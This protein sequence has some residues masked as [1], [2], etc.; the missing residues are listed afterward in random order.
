MSRAVWHQK[1]IR[2]CVMVLLAVVLLAVASASP[3]AQQPTTGLNIAPVYEGWEQNADGSFDLIFGYFNRNWNEWIDTPAGAANS[4]EPGGPDQGQPTHFLPRRNQFV[5]R[6]RVPRDFGSRELVWTLTTNGKTEK[7]Y[8]T[9]KPDYVVN[10]T[11]MAANFGAG[12]QTGT[13][14]DL[15]GNVAPV[16]K[17]EGERTR[18]VRV[19]EPVALV[20]V[21][22][23]DG[24]PRVRQ[25]QNF[26][27]RTV[28]NSATGLR[29]VWFKYRGAGDV[30]FDPPQFS[31]WED[32]RNGANSPWA[33]GWRT[34]PIPTDNTWETR[35]T[36]KT[37][38]EYV[39]R[40]VAHDGAIT[41]IENI[42]V[43]VTP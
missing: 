22:T 33:P 41:A 36:F 34:P 38:G 19:G 11:V 40:C 9:L 8:G 30:T 23:D 1:M 5:F 10:A 31:A 28:P 20:A 26:G 32:T 29:L 25:M 7:A 13:M 2:V 27:M 3:A 37:P 6:I 24:K 16:L 12:G 18:R 21:A 43:V 35:A 14:P 39:L 17:L 42:T 4:I 15:A